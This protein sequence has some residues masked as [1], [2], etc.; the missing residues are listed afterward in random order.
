MP[1]IRRPDRVASEEGEVMLKR[2][3]YI[4]TVVP[5]SAVT[6][7]VAVPGSDAA[8]VITRVALLSVVVAVTTGMAIVPNGSV[9]E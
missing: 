2:M 9:I 7:T 8:W 3:L 4:L 1:S 6:R 5:F